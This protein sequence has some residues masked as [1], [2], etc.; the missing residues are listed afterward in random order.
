MTTKPTKWSTNE[1]GAN[2]IACTGCPA[3]CCK[4]LPSR[5]PIYRLPLNEEG[6]CAHLIEDKCS[7]Y[8]TRPAICRTHK[9]L[10][11]LMDQ[12]ASICDVLKAT[13]G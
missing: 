11:T 9:M 4:I 5:H 13:Y 12:T 3:H 8:A 10:A 6:H 7:I 1:S 2:S